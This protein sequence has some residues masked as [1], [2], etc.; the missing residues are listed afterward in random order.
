M[1]RPRPMRRWLAALIPPLAVMLLAVG[2]LPAVAAQD[3]QPLPRVA[4]VTRNDVPFDSLA[5]GPVAGALGAVTVITP[6]SQLSSPAQQALQSFAP[7]RVYIIGGTAAISTATENQISNAGSWTVQRIAGTSRDDTARRLA[8]LPATLGYERPVLT[9]NG[10]INGQFSPF[11]AFDGHDHGINPDAGG[12]AAR[13]G[14][15]ETGTASGVGT[16]PTVVAELTIP[17]QN[18]RNQCPAFFP[19]HN[20]LVEVSGTVSVA[21]AH[22]VVAEEAVTLNSTAWPTASP[23][24]ASIRRQRID[25]TAGGTGYASF[26]SQ[27][28]FTV[29][30]S[31]S[32]STTIRLLARAGTAQTG[33]PQL[34]AVD[35][36]LTVLHL[37]YECSP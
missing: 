8:Q 16:S 33:T 34:S 21:A 4:F 7:D 5:V 12:A 30:Q 10:D 15:L 24:Q 14:G 25:T 35:G 28:L 19:I 36:T 1:P 18:L 9:P 23:A 13:Q 27:V 6:P 37:G 32:G 31:T 26:A 20:L 11:Y 2:L 22:D 3:P 29:P 17:N